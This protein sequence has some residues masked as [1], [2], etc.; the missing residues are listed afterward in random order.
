M[1]LK[2]FKEYKKINEEGIEIQVELPQGITPIYFGKLLH[3]RDVAH[4]I[5]LSTQKYEVHMATKE[6]YDAILDLVDD[7]I[8]QYQGLHGIVPISIPES[9]SVDPIIYF[10]ELFSSVQRDKKIFIES[11]L[12]NIVD[13]ILSTIS[14]LL[15]KLKFLH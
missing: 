15:Y 14:K 13:E 4:L 2:S 6:Y 10:T 9:V 3:S 12:L 1:S 8:E 5:H 7:L 11:N